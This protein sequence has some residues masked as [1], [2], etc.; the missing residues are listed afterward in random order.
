MRVPGR[1]KERKGR[2]RL[3]WQGIQQS[4]GMSGVKLHG[5]DRCLISTRI[6]PGKSCPMVRDCQIEQPRSK[7]SVF[8][9]VGSGSAAQD[10]LALLL[11]R[12]GKMIASLPTG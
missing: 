7:K 5:F 9:S 2:Q 3:N 11:H 1:G 6:C 10:D 4:D 8:V 12:A